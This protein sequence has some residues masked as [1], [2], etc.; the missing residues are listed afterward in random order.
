M[1]HLFIFIFV[2]ARISP[3]N[4]TPVGDELLI[5][6]NCLMEKSSNSSNL[7]YD[8]HLHPSVH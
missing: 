2:V 1:S 5:P 7:S 4:R 8:L 6:D 3:I